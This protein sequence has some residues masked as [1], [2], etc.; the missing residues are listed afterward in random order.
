MYTKDER[1]VIYSLIRKFGITSR[2]KGYHYTVDAVL[3][4]L[5]TE[6]SELSIMITK[7]VYPKLTKK[8]NAKGTNGIERNIRTVA[9]LC[10]SNNRELLESIAGYPLPSRPTNAEFLTILSYYIKC[11]TK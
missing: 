8:Y 10:W 9:E 6:R 3:L 7:D 1:E 5:E 2:Y 11:M 4:Y